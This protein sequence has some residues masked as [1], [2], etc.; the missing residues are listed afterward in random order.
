MAGKAGILDG[1]VVD[2]NTIEMWYHHA[3][4]M[5]ALVN[6]NQMKRAK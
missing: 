5:S 6:C 1:V 3:N 2:A 4:A